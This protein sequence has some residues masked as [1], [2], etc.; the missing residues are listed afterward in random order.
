MINIL[1]K[2]KINFAFLSLSIVLLF[3]SLISLFFGIQL[4]CIGIVG[5]YIGKVY[6]ETKNR[7][8]YIISENLIELS[9]KK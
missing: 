1:K 4:F 9:K 7:P 8:R 5:D 6:F 3:F 2:D